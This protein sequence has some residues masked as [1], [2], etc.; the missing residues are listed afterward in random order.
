MNRTRLAAVP[1]AVLGIV[2]SGSV[3]A[4]TPSDPEPVDSTSASAPPVLRPIP[5]HTGPGAA[6]REN[7]LDV[8]ERALAAYQRAAAVMAP[9]DPECHLT[10]EL[11]AAVGRVESDHGRYAAWRLGPRARMFPALVGSPMSA[12]AQATA[13]PLADTDGGV[14]DHDAAADH[15]LG[16]LQILPGAWRQVAVDGDGD[17]LRS[18]DDLDDAALGLAIELCDGDLD[19][20]TP[21]GQAE[22]LAR[23][24]ARRG[25]QRSVEAFRSAYAAP[26]PIT[27]VT[28][29]A[30]GTIVSPPE[31]DAA[32]P[33]KKPGGG[34]KTNGPTKSGTGSHAPQTGPSTSGPTPGPVKPPSTT[35]T[36][37][38]PTPTPT[39]TPAPVVDPTPTPD[40]TPDP[41]PSEPALTPDPTASTDAS[42]IAD[43]STTPDLATTTAP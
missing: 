27:P 10:P 30:I 11:L 39:P 15:P 4:A 17:G 16:P 13:S 36:V 12:R 43:P 26:L 14:F 34:S 7:L 22:A 33:G 23:L 32:A 29:Y 3:A 8:P 35:P 18:P 37:P 31:K 5:R 2:A 42:R 19:L 28:V 24:N 40:P 38:H 1:V 20:A 25:Y 6:A 21:S 9:A 41:T